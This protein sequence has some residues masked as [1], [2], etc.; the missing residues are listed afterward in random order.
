M[1][2]RRTRPRLTAC[3]SVGDSATN[4]VPDSQVRA[5]RGSLLGAGDEASD[6]YNDEAG[7]PLRFDWKLSLLNPLFNG[8]L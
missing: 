3:P 5:G 4:R 6:L 8:P 2:E 7:L 1:H